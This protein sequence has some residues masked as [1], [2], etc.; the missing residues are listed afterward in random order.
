[1]KVVFFA[2]SR[3]A[4]GCGEC[5][6]EWEHPVT[7]AEFW[8]RLVQLYPGLSSLQKTARLARRESYLAEGEQL[9]PQDE[10]AVLPPVSGG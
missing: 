9:D 10:I 3:Q 6:L 4:A 5:R 7:A 2:Q 1:M 8:A